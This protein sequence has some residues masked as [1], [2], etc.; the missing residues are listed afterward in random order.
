MHS[1]KAF[2]SY[3]DA[4]LF[5][6]SHAARG[7]YR[8]DHLCVCVCVLALFSFVMEGMGQ[9]DAEDR[10]PIGHAVAISL[11][12]IAAQSGRRKA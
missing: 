9:R 2:W 6:I 3:V 8:V 1:S 12:P 10:L 4:A 7:T 11:A 5:D